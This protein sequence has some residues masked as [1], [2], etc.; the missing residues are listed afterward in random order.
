MKLLPL[1]NDFVFKAV[2]AKHPDLLIDLLNSFPEF[3]GEHQLR[4]LTVLNPDLPGTFKEEKHSILDIKAVSLNGDKF[5][6]EMQAAPQIFF[7]KR[8]VFYWSKVYSKSIK[9]GQVYDKLPK[10]YSFNFTKFILFPT[11]SHFHAVFK[12]LEKEN[13]EILLTMI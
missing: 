4:S 10:V 1:S 6:I 11:R 5:L 9:K 13:S 3:S 8:V 7:T 12:I 2:L